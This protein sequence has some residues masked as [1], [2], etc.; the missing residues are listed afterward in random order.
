MKSIVWLFFLS[1]LN[2]WVCRCEVK[3]KA[4]FTVPYDTNE[5]EISGDGSCYLLIK[6]S[7]LE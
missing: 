1:L 4:K 2:L 6:Y 5:I 3:I 7:I